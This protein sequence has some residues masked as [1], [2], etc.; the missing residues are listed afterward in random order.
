M[1]IV[2]SVFT[3]AIRPPVYSTIGEKFGNSKRPPHCHERAPP[4]AC[5]YDSTTGPDGRCGNVWTRYTAPARRARNQPHSLFLTHARC[6]PVPWGITSTS[7]RIEIKYEPTHDRTAKRTSYPAHLNVRYI[8][9]TSS[10]RR[11]QSIT[12]SRKNDTIGKCTAYSIEDLVCC[13]RRNGRHLS[14][15]AIPSLTTSSSVI[16]Q[17]VKTMPRQK[18]YLN[19]TPAGAD[20]D[21]NEF[22]ARCN[23]K[24]P[25]HGLARSGTTSTKKT[26]SARA[27][28]HVGLL[29]R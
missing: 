15:Y 24:P 11:V 6:S 18:V 21:K 23:R 29:A 16:I 3:S 7:T 8:E 12:P 19:S 17:R 25:G 13:S 14:L 10:V 5:I 1:L 27:V 4:S 9:N 20:S 2:A 28:E 22:C 26:H